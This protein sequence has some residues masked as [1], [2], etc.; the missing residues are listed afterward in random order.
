[1]PMAALFITVK[2]WEH[3]KCPLTD[4]QANKMWYSQN[5][6]LFSNKRNE[7]MTDASKQMN[8][9]NE[10]VPKTTYTHTY[11]CTCMYVLYDFLYMQ[12]CPE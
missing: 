6:I 9:K 1:M 10:S 2:K 5:G 7:V 8:L 3:C 12:K 11:L 4:T